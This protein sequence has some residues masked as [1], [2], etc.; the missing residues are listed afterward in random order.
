[1]LI[2]TA[3]GLTKSFGERLHECSAGEAGPTLA[4][5][6]SPQI[7]LIPSLMLGK[8]K[9]AVPTARRRMEKS[10]AGSFTSGAQFIAD[11]YAAFHHELDSFHLG[12]VLQRIAGYCHEIRKFM[13]FDRAEAVLH[14]NDIGIHRGRGT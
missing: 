3:R 8:R 13:R 6:P 14:V 11:N 7:L 12:N 4:A 9:A 2:N 1:M 5:E 10:Y